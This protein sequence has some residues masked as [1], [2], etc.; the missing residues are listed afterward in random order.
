MTG[1]T[2]YIFE[3]DGNGLAVSPPLPDALTPT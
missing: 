1:P 2:Y 3:K